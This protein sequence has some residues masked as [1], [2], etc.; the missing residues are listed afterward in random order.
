M[1]IETPR[2]L[3]DPLTPADEAPLA[4][5]AGDRRVA[6]MLGSFPSPCPP[7]KARE[8]IGRSRDTSRPGFR[9]AVRHEGLLA[10]TVGISPLPE[11]GAPTISYFLDPPLWG[12]GLMSEAL[13]A[14]LPALCA[15][16]A[17]PAI[18]ATV[19]EDNPASIRA[20]ERVGFRV[21]GRLHEPSAARE[22]TWPSVL[23][24]RAR[25]ERRGAPTP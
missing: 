15:A 20:L 22:G 18:E 23:M 25:P 10:G 4:R 1:R 7:E 14:F 13:S 5:I 9:L 6:R 24:R 17:L 19:F 2:L 8:V 16:F 21:A 11:R 12:R 3:I